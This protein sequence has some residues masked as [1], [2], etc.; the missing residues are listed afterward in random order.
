M[1]F[2]FNINHIS[3]ENK[4]IYHNEDASIVY[5]TNGYINVFY[6]SSNYLMTLNKGFLCIVPFDEYSF[7][8]AVNG[9]ICILNINKFMV[10]TLASNIYE[11]FLLKNFYP[12][13]QSFNFDKVCDHLNTLN[14][15][16]PYHKEQ[17]TTTVS[18]NIITLLDDIK[19]PPYANIPTNNSYVCQYQH[20]YGQRHLFKATVALIFNKNQSISEIALEHGFYDQAHFTKVF[21]NHRNMTPLHFRKRYNVFSHYK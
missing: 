15:L 11:Y 10:Y 4:W 8:Y 16:A 5:V 7:I 14:N 18:T 1:M 21:K 13:I 9:Q 12:I 2:N 6:H 3:H 20:Y 17:F 19:L